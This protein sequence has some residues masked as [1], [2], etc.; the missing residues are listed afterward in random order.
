MSQKMV[1]PSDAAEPHAGGSS[2]SSTVTW[3]KGLEVNLLYERVGGGGGGGG[4]SV[5]SMEMGNRAY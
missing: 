1:N 5:L 4:G 2:V 3:Q